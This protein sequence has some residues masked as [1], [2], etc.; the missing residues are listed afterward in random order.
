MGRIDKGLAIAIFFK[1]WWISTLT[2]K[3]SKQ[4]PSEQ[5]FLFSRTLHGI[6]IVLKTK[7]VGFQ[8]FTQLLYLLHEDYTYFS[9][10]DQFVMAKVIVKI[11][12]SNEYEDSFAILTYDTMSYKSFAHLF[13]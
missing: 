9:W 10:L 11:K 8:G 6:S 5:I 2:P 3:L 12:W 13:K 1:Q 4:G 7:K